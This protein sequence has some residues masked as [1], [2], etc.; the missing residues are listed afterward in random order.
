MGSYSANLV[1]ILIFCLILVGCG[2]EKTPIPATPTLDPIA[3]AGQRYFQLHCGA[4]HA[5]V[6][7]VV[8]V[9]PSL[10]GIS[11]TAGTRMP[12]RSA[13]DYIFLSIMRPNDFIVDGYSEAMPQDFGKKLTGEEVDAIV[14]YLLTLE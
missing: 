3:Q 12:N 5:V 8:V 1:V 11:T 13:E 14:A 10:A 9:G 7:D 4:C 2:E 6:P